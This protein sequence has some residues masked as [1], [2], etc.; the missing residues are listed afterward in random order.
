MFSQVTRN[1]IRGKSLWLS[2]GRL[3]PNIRKNIFTERVVKHCNR[4]P[5]EAL[6]S[7][8][9]E[10]FKRYIDTAAWDMV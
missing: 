10:L 9:P 3:R 7:T 6:Q 5:R 8:S 4:L 2:H 1:R